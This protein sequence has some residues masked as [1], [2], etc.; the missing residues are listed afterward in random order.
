MVEVIIHTLKRREPVFRKDPSRH[1]KRTERQD[2]ATEAYMN[3]TSKPP[4]TVY[5]ALQK[6]S[7]M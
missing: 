6:L 7:P 3:A 4:S 2:S 1:N 5:P